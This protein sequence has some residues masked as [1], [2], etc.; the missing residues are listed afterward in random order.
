MTGVQTCA[1]PILADN[2]WSRANLLR[3]AQAHGV[4][5][6]RL[7]F[8]PRV[9]PPDYLAR[10]QLA[11]LMLDTFPYN[12]GTTASDALWMG[13]PILTLAGAATSRAWPAACS[14]PSACPTW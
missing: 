4:A 6:E 13:L 11:D 3:V 7:V 1:L 5:A 9:A 12:A 8:A 10:F 2:D 14:P